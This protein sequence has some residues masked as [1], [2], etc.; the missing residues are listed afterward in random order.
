MSP[1]ISFIIAGFAMFG[2]P[3]PAIMSVAATGAAFGFRRGLSYAAGIIVGTIVVA[4]LVATGLA[5]L[6]FFIPG[7]KPILIVGAALYIIY[8]AY[9]IAMAP[10]LGKSEASSHAPKFWNGLAL[11][12]ANPKAYAG[13]GAVFSSHTLVA[14]APM[15]DGLVK[16]T[17]LFLIICITDP[18]WLV[19]GGA[20]SKV[21][22]N[23][24]IS[25]TINIFLAL[26][27][28]LAVGL[29]IPAALDF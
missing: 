23:P 9:R 29:T 2:S 11:A 19:L 21:M 22:T 12:L 13:V 27:L 8:L 26:A 17:A 10:P 15:L 16:I 6:I 3:G 14:D 4:I 28:L 24:R 1:Y 25:R 20:L 5:G 18:I 7:A